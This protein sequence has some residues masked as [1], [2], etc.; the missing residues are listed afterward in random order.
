MAQC[1]YAPRFL[2][3][4]FST[5]FAHK[6]N[7]KLK[8]LLFESFIPAFFIAEF[9]HDVVCRSVERLAVANAKALAARQG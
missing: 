3:A 6:M 9:P 5:C 8:C 7:F 4:S 2:L 1:P